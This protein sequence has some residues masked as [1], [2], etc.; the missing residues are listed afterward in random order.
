[1]DY[2]NNTT[3]FSNVNLEELNSNYHN[4]LLSKG[5]ATAA[6]L[7]KVAVCWDELFECVSPA[8]TDDWRL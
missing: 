2:I 4:F 1:M 7:C 8:V 3:V 5:K 6:S